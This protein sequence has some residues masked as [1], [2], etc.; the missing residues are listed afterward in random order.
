MHLSKASPDGQKV[1]TVVGR[2]F[3]GMF[4]LE[5]LGKNDRQ[6][7]SAAR[8]GA[9]VLWSSDSKSIAVTTCLGGSGPCYVW[10]DPVDETDAGTDDWN[11]S[12]LVV[13]A[14]STNHKDDPCYTWANV[15]ALT[16]LGGS[17]KIVIVA[18]VP[19]SGGCWGHNPGY[20]EAFTISLSE[21][22]I[23]S[24]SNMQQTIQ[25]WPNLLGNGLRS[26]IKVTQEDRPTAKQK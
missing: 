9:E 19:T 11:L 17:D 4:F 12:K 1:L 5:T 23:L 21:R 3:E 20:F 2:E 16:W 22:K 13:E 10:I 6:P 18:E 8:A 15:G 25:Q 7:F 24:Q 14:F 26:D